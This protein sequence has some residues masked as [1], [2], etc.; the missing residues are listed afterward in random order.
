MKVVKIIDQL[1][2]TQI[3]IQE[4]DW[5]RTHTLEIGIRNKNVNLK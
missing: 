4:L 5:L 2:W 3:D 1:L